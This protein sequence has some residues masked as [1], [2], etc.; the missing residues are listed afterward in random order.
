MLS[1]L[2]YAFI[3]TPSSAGIAAFVETALET[4]DTAFA[5]SVLKHEIFTAVFF[6]Y[7]NNIYF[8]VVVVGDVK[9]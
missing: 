1:L 8:F 6:S 9:I 4:F 7:L 5:R 3:S 2:S